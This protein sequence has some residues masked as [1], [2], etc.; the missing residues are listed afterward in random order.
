[1]DHALARPVDVG[2]SGRRAGDIG[3]AAAAVLALPH[4]HGI[5]CRTVGRTLDHLSPLW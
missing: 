5:L 4:L 3:H 1:M 2:R